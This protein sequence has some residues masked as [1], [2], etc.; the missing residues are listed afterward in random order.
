MYA[1]VRRYEGI[2]DIDELVRRS[3]DEVVPI[4]REVSGFVAYYVIDAGGGTGVSISI[5]EDQAGAEESTQRAARM[6]SEN[7]AALFTSRPQVTSGAVRLAAT[8]Q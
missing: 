8:R 1:A 3:D 5:Y 2:T 6:V 7:L 4:L